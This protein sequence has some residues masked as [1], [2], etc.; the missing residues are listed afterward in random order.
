MD[1]NLDIIIP[2][3]IIRDQRLE[4]SGKI[5]YGLLFAKTAGFGYC[6]PKNRELAYFMNLS[7]RSISHLLATLEFLGY[8]ERTVIKDTETNEVLERRIYLTK[9]PWTQR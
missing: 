2:V 3:E 4:D 7:V 9:K 8:I 5:L 6:V 1:S